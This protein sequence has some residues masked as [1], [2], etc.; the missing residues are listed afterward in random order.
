MIILKEVR[1][2]TNSQ[3]L[4]TV[5]VNMHDHSSHLPSYEKGKKKK[6][7]KLTASSNW[8]EVKSRQHNR[9]ILQGVFFLSVIFE[10]QLS[11]H[12]AGK[13][14]AQQTAQERPKSMEHAL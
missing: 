10:G 4:T 3:S 12:R 14:A 7:N 8:L 1:H 2:T 11:A 5:F 13:M 9:E 6:E